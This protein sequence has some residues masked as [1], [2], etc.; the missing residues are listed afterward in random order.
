LAYLAQTTTDAPLMILLVSR[1]TE[2]E[3]VLQ[4]LIAAARKSSRR[5]LDIQLRALSE[6]EEQLLVHQ[7]LRQTTPE[8]E[9]IKAR[10]ARRAEGNPF[11]TEE[12][13]RMLIE[14]GGLTGRPGNWQVTPRAAELLQE[15]PETLKGL[16]LARFD[17]LSEELRRT[18]QKA[19]VLGRS[20]PVSLLLSLNGTKPEVLARQ[21]DE[22]A[23]RQFLVVEACGPEPSYAFRHALIREAV[24]GTLLNRQRQA[25]HE[26][27]ARAVE[28]STFWPPDEQTEVLAYH[29]AQ[30]TDP[31][32][33]VPFLMTAAGNA[34]QRSANPQGASGSESALQYFRRAIALM[35]G[36]PVGGPVA[37]A[38]PA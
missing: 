30:S 26:A 23:D 18:L 25:L 1:D 37:C 11:Y 32:R 14:Q 13:I 20:F 19:A 10:I 27:A 6:A 31:S 4:P 22:L 16:L 29:Y 2:R 12:I 3:T 7:L 17:R 8:A 36:Q 34:A 33:A 24:Y 5:L 38:A 9:A 35:Q 28:C 15:V 21:L